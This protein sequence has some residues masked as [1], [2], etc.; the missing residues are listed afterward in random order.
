MVPTVAPGL[1][2]CRL[3]ES[4]VAPVAAAAWSRSRASLAKPKSNSFAGPRKV[5]K[6]LDF[7]SSH[8]TIRVEGGP[9]LNRHQHFGHFAP[10]SL[11]RSTQLQFLR[12]AASVIKKS[13]GCPLCSNNAGGEV[14]SDDATAS[15]DDAAAARRIPGRYAEVGAVGSGQRGIS[16]SH[17]RTAHVRNRD[18]G[19]APTA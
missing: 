6:M 1:V 5:M 10:A 7:D 9:L 19:I 17:C 8:R 13:V 16:D 3:V 15:T 2:R 14:N 12:V 4:E 18:A 11:S